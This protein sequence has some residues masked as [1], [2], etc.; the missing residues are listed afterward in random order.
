MQGRAAVVPLEQ[1]EAVAF[2]HAFRPIQGARGPVRAQTRH[3]V[4][5]LRSGARTTLGLIFHD[6]E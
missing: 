1:G 5:E 6:A 3:G 4:G 2:P